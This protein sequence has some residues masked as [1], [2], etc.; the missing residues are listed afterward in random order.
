[1][2]VAKKDGLVTVSSPAEE[3]A[4]MLL[5][6]VETAESQVEGSCYTELL[7][8]L[9]YMEPEDEDLTALT[10]WQVT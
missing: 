10:P 9:P 4:T 7:P 3:E 1:M 5:T 2:E 6:V 8:D